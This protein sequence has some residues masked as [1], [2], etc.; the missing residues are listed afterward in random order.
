MAAQ[1]RLHLEVGL[2]PRDA[3]ASARRAVSRSRVVV[4]GARS[5]AGRFMETQNLFNWLATK[6]S[7]IFATK[8]PAFPTTR[9]Q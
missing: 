9:D 7:T 2:L 5:N 3:A 4:L 6:A 1:D 8:A